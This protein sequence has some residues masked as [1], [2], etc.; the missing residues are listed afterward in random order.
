MKPAS[1]DRTRSPPVPNSDGLGLALSEDLQQLLNGQG[2]S[3][4]T[5][6]EG[7]EERLRRDPKQRRE[8]LIAILE[9]VLRMI[10][11]VESDDKNDTSST[12]VDSGAARGGE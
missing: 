4:A 10:D 5:A 7:E 8:M 9:S 11:G 12:E 6:T 1:D 3:T 2:E